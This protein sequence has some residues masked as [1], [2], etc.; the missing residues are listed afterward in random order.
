M[1]KTRKKHG[2][3]VFLARRGAKSAAVCALCRTETP[4][5]LQDLALFFVGFLRIV[6]LFCDKYEL[7]AVFLLQCPVKAGLVADVALAGIDGYFQNQAVLV[8]IYEYLLYSLEVAALLAF[9]PQLAARSAE[10]RGVARLDCCV[11]CLT[12][13]V[14]DHEDLAGPAVLSYRRY[15]A[16]VI[17]SW[18]KLHTFFEVLFCGHLLAP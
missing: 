15:Q 18:D 1:P 8:A 12:I 13:H 3:E 4:L 10:I 7:S 2:I 5:R 11:Q 14:S 6:G 9:L 16:V 17:E